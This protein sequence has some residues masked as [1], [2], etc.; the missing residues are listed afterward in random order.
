MRLEEIIEELESLANPEAAAGMARY[1]IQGKVVYGILMPALRK[2]AKSI[3]KDPLLAQKLWDTGIHEARILA[4]I[5]DMPKAVTEAQMEAWVHD[6]DAWDVCDQCC[7]NLFR[8]TP[9]AYQKAFEWSER[10]EEFVKRAAFAL[11]ATLAVHDKKAPDSTFE[12]LLPI[13]TREAGDERNFVKKAVNWALRQI[14]KRNLNLNTAAIQTAQ[15]IEAI[16]SKSARWIA[17]DALRELAGDKVQQKLRQ[18]Q[19][20]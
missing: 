11:I 13:I 7:I 19:E 16:D 2:L 9:F 20:K 18:N 6:F 1:G 14:G 3:G 17:K 12:Q 5:V 4:S 10:D 15:T 8:K